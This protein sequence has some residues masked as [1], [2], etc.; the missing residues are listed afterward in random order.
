[1]F[2]LLKHAL[3]AGP[4]AS[5]VTA[6]SW[7]PAEADESCKAAK[8]EGPKQLRVVCACSEPMFSDCAP[9]GLKLPNGWVKLAI[10]YSKKN[11]AEEGKGRG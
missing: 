11:R 7:D 1:M 8:K 6:V 9:G 4:E 3:R 10:T 5:S 2:L